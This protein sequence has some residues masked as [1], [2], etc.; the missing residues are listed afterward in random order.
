MTNPKDNQK[1]AIEASLM[2]FNE[3]FNNLREN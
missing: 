1:L 2:D 3:K